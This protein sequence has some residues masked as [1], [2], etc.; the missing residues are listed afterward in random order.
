MKNRG[1]TDIICLLIFLAHYAAFGFVTF[2][3]MSDG[4]PSKLYKL[5]DYQ[6]NYC[7][8]KKQWNNDLDLEKQEMLIYMMNVSTAVEGPFLEA[9]C[10]HAVERELNNIGGVSFDSTELAAYRCAC[11][12][13]PCPGCFTGSINQPDLKT[14]ADIRVQI[15]QK[16]AG[17]QNKPGAISV[18]SPNGP[19][20]GAF[21]NVFND[22]EKY[23]VPVCS[24]SCSE[25]NPGEN[26]SRT[27][28]YA[29]FPDDPIFYPWHLLTRPENAGKVSPD[30]RNTMINAF[31]F[32]A[33]PKSVCPY[34]D[35]YCVPFPGVE[36]E[37]KWNNF[38]MFKLGSEAID[39]VGTAV[40]DAYTSLGLKNI[41]EKVTETFGSMTGDFVDTLD[42]FAIVA[43]AA[44]VIGIIF[45]VLLRFFVGCVVWTSITIVLLLFAFGGIL[46]WIRHF[47]CKNVG[48]FE[49]GEQTAS[50]VVSTGS[51]Y[52]SGGDL[53]NE[54][55]TGKGEDYRG[56]QFKTRSG[57]T[58]QAW[59]VN[60]PQAHSYKNSTY[61]DAG[62]IKN[63]CRNPLGSA[64]TIW[65]YTTDPEMRWETCSPIG[66]IVASCP[67][68]YEVESKDMRKVLEILAFV[69]WGFGA[70]WLLMIL[71]LC[72]QI[73]LAI[74]I[75]KAA[76]V[77]VATSPSILL[78]P[79]CQVI[80]AIIW[81]LAW[82][83]SAAFLL[84]QVPD[85]HVPKKFFATYAE[86]YGTDDD[87]G[88]CTGPFINGYVWR[89]AGNLAVDGDPCSGNQGDTTGITP[90]CWGCY[91]PR[92]VV[93]WRVAVSFFSFLWTNAFLIALGQIIIAGAVCF[94]F[95][96]KREEKFKIFSTRKGIGLAFR[97]HL[98]SIAFGS[99]I[100]AVVQFAR[101]TLAYIEKQAKAAK[102]MA[103]VWVL[104]AVQCCLW[105]LE[106]CIRFLNKNAY[107]QV[108]LLGKN[109]CT[110][111]KAAFYLILRNMARFAAVAMLGNIIEVV[112]FMFIM[113][114]TGV[115][116][117][118]ILKAM[119]PDV[120]PIVPLIVH[121]AMGYV[122]AKLYMNVFALAV[123]TILQCF[124]ATEEMG[125]DGGWVPSSMDSLIKDAQEPDKA[126]AED[127][128]KAAAGAG[129][130]I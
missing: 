96:T 78:V 125:G 49:S 89:Y 105:C 18:F 43:V 88:E 104:R 59:S 16:M 58:C 114:A 62:L 68:G 54:D 111:A 122:V 21:Q 42:A 117:Y 71:C 121:C 74:A 112:G 34:E 56:A 61:P 77:F 118:F 26:S 92:Y 81:T 110:S 67:Q 80:T 79:M 35:R 103:M 17:L 47:Q 102:N 100:V 116:S 53:G 127:S 29:P 24:T 2:L 25:V 38:C 70:L 46:C 14:G 101:Y 94:W 30:V 83:V 23:F 130:E 76:A 60:S 126:K 72:R 106:K 95:F 36:F 37:E 31:T 66:A 124:I 55:M 12:K 113:I 45:L 123:A 75:N 85:G 64:A 41:E 109:F 63:Y 120:T 93:D 1:C 108:A 7:G 98:G 40:S 4:D 115:S 9:M 69:I 91:P 32:Q 107:I 33:M 119:H 129:T 97:Y 73:C 11:C 13:D 82:A 27:Y 90:K 19:N 5:R 65:C 3:G 39:A 15:A 86:A 8:V 44:F 52:M 48:L 99:F 128:S 10:S 6:G 22:F 50:A 57:R 20:A 84:S 87:A 51:H 28:Q